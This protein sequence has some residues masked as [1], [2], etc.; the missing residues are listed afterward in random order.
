MF[1]F[2]KSFQ[3]FSIILTIFGLKKIEIKS[4]CSKLLIKFYYLLIAIISLRILW[5]F[6]IS[7][8]NAKHENFLVFISHLDIFVYTVVT[9]LLF[10]NNRRASEKVI[11]CF[12]VFDTIAEGHGIVFNYKN[13]FD[14]SLKLVTPTVIFLACCTFENLLK[15]DSVFKQ[16]LV[17]SNYCFYFI[18]VA[19]VSFFIFIVFNIKI[20]LEK[21][22]EK[23]QELKTFRK[24]FPQDFLLVFHDLLKLIKQISDEF[25]WNLGLIFC[26][27]EICFRF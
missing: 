24:N 4:L 19:V 25:W 7:T 2:D 5:K 12:Q 22:K 18:Y 17:I 3:L 1:D 14:F 20:R 6:C 26:V 11:K 21:L 8:F 9:I 13:I 16:F 10:Y 27:F 15:V 23:M